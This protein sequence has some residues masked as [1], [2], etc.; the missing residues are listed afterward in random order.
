MYAVQMEV[1]D[2]MWMI[3]IDFASLTWKGLLLYPFQGKERLPGCRSW[4]AELQ[5]KNLIH[6]KYEDSIIDYC[7]FNTVAEL[8][9]FNMK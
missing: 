4:L 8:L 3:K 7:Q 6:S 1:A 5:R 2:V 9:L